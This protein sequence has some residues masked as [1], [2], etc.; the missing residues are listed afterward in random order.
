MEKILEGFRLFPAA[1]GVGGVYH[2]T[3]EDIQANIFARFYANFDK[4]YFPRTDISVVYSNYSGGYNR[5]GNTANMAYKKSVFK[6]IGLFDENISYT[7]QTDW[8]FRTRCLAYGFGLVT[9]PLDI[10]HHKKFTLKKFIL[11][12]I[13]Q[14]RGQNFCDTKY[15]DRPEYKKTQTILGIFELYSEWI[16]VPPYAGSSGIFLLYLVCRLLVE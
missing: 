15:P 1:V 7:G 12:S 3:A 10:V 8:E 5:A 4:K 14:G 11:K 9:L 2:Y 13:A 6:K 16:H